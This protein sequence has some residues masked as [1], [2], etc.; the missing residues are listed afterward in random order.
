VDCRLEASAA[1]STAARQS[2]DPES[3]SSISSV[4]IRVEN[5]FFF[6]PFFPVFE[7]SLGSGGSFCLIGRA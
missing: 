1:G 7:N 5:A 2:I 6:V 3:H 4:S